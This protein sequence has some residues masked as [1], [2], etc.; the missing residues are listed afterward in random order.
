MKYQEYIDREIVMES[1]KAYLVKVEVD[2]R[3]D[4]QYTNFIW[5]AK[6]K[7]KKAHRYS[8]AELMKKINALPNEIKATLPRYI[9]VPTWLIGESRW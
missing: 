1:E 9:G 6:S 5:V 2:N 8:D 3:R 7:C 4:G